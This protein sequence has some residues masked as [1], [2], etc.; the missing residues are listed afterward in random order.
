[1]MQRVT[2]PSDNARALAFGSRAEEYDR[3]RP[4]YPTAAVDWL[5]PPWAQKV[6][7][8]GAGTGKLTGLLVQRGLQ[9][10][11]IEPDPEML[12]VLSRRYPQV[13]THLSSAD[14]LPLPDGSVDAVLV[15][16]A[17]HW[18]PAREA[19]AEVRRV[20]RPGGWLGLVWNTD[21]PHEEWEFDLSRLNP[22]NRERDFIA[23]R[24]VPDHVPVPGLP[25]DE[26]EAAR[27][28]W[29][30]DATADDVCN[31]LATHSAVILMDHAERAQLL[32]AASAIVREQASDEAT[33]VIPLR[34]ASFCVRWRPRTH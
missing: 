33:S 11:A 14:R 22:D 9:V 32:D 23:E 34:Q 8:V 28:S 24:T 4:S 6:A 31:R 29:T 7:D 21:D 17:W 27:F 15:G 10:A 13:I 5:L 30:Q 19:A 18:F 16:Q 3:Y 25:T 2:E 20:L 1:M 12:A 26:L